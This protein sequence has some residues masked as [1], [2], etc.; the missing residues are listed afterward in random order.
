MLIFEHHISNLI[1]LQTFFSLNYY[2]YKFLGIRVK[3]VRI[4]FNWEVIL[5][6]KIIKCYNIFIL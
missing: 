6:R 2:L 5:E 4:Y 3:D 1:A